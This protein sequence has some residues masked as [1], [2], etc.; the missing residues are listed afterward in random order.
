MNRF[1]DNLDHAIIDLMLDR[2][3]R[4]ERLAN[5]TVLGGLMVVGLAIVLA[6]LYG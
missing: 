4:A 2:A 3:Y 5:W 6:S 1:S